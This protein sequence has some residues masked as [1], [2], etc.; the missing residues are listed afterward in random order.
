MGKKQPELS[1]IPPRMHPSVAPVAKGNYVKH[2]F[3][4]IPSMVVPFIRRLSTV[5]AC[6]VSRSCQVAILNGLVDFAI[7]CQTG[8]ASSMPHVGQLRA[9]WEF[10]VEVLGWLRN[11][12]QMAILTAAYLCES[13]LRR[14]GHVQSPS[15]DRGVVY[16]DGITP[17][18]S[19]KRQVFRIRAPII[20]LAC[21]LGVLAACL[22]GDPLPIEITETPQAPNLPPGATVAPSPYP[23]DGAGETATPGDS[24]ESAP[25]LATPTHIVGELVAV[26]TPLGGEDYPAV[27]NRD[28]V[29]RL[30]YEGDRLEPV[31]YVNG[32]GEIEQFYHMQDEIVIVQGQMDWYGTDWCI[33]DRIGFEVVQCECLEALD[34]SP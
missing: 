16:I 31:T 28:L 33:V 30:R 9:V 11:A 14:G 34:E 8:L 24:G 13:F 27:V 29:I 18:A 2:R 21:C 3:L 12:C 23:E 1:H 5:S 20:I 25:Q 10:P 7:F 22:A 6:Q 32:D 4:S 17:T 26:A 15:Q 19:I